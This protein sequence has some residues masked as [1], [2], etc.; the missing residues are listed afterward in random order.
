[1]VV[2]TTIKG[3]NKMKTIIAKDYIK[4]GFS[5]DEAALLQPEIGK[6]VS[7]ST[8]FVLDFDQVQYFTTLFFSTALTYLVDHL[9]VDGYNRMVTVKNLSESGQET[10]K[11][12]Y[13]YAIQYYNMTPRE[14]KRE[15]QIINE[16][17]EK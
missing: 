16:E 10:Y 2:S 3:K 15:R 8:P 1:M 7:E 6:A 4:S 17:T 5:E 14:Q 13:D 11:H 9:G 12:A